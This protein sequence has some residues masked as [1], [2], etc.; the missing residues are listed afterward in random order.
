[1]RHLSQ[2]LNWIWLSTATAGVVILLAVVGCGPAGPRL[3]RPAFELPTAFSAAGVEPL[4]E[5]WWLSLDDPALNT[6]IE[7]ALSGNFTIRSAWDRLTQAEQIA[8]QAGAALYPSATY[9]AGG[10]R[11]RRETGNITTYTT[12]YFAN[13]AAGYELD[14]WGRVKSARHAAVLDAE[15]AQE[16]VSAAA[17]TVS[18]TVARTWYQLAE[19]KQQEQI[20][21]RQ[22]ETNRKILEVIKVQFRQ[23]QVGAADVFSQEQLV[24]SS[25]SQL[26]QVRE[27]ISVLQHLLSVLTGKVP[28]TWWSEQSLELISL[29]QMP[30]IDVPAVVIQRR[31]D[32]VSAYRTV[33]AADMR[34]ASAIAD[35]YPAISLSAAAETSA[36]RAEDL[37][38]DWLG[39]LA[40]N[41]TGPLFDAGLR[42]AEVRRN[43]AVVSERLNNYSQAVLDALQETEDAISQ[44]QYQRQYVE[45]LQKQLV[46]ARDVY[47]RTYQNYLKGQLDYIRVLTALVSMQNLEQNELIA[48]RVLIERRIDLCRSI[49]GGWPL[50]RPDDAELI[51]Q[52]LFDEKETHEN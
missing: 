21:L 29:G 5:E 9:G 18:A 27:N 10:E 26:I 30:V 14:L 46:L 3:V 38:D 13:A 23:S 19:A 43:R 36:A 33:Q 35:Q 39:N 42:K 40:A 22:I 48:R 31:P 52:S 20:I 6:V 17:M 45:S 7:E 28:G 1:V 37:F 15:A 32:V 8:I 2:K 44:E 49:A 16:N 41:L 25:R 12:D 11:I 24:E 4:P 47:E 50:E 34:L 51:S